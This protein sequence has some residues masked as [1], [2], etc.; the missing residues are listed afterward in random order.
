MAAGRRACR[1]S[2]SVDNPLRV[3]PTNLQISINRDKAGLLGLSSAEAARDV[4][5]GIAGLVLWRVAPGSRWEEG[6][7]LQDE[8]ADEASPSPHASTGATSVGSPVTIFSSCTLIFFPGN[9]H[10]DCDW[11]LRIRDYPNGLYRE[12]PEAH[13]LQEWHDPCDRYWEHERTRLP[14]QPDTS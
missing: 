12:L 6:A 4:R 11:Q 14:D 2:E 1:P 7:E 5:L 8:H 3:K 9:L 13:Y 10:G